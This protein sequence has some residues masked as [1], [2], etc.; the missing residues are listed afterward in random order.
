VTAPRR[1]TLSRQA[2]RVGAL[3]PLSVLVGVPLAIWPA[4]AVA[5]LAALAGLLCA[6]GI[7]AGARTFVLAGAAAALVEYALALAASAGPPRPLA[8]A[9]LGVALAL[10]LD[11]A[12]F[13]R[14]FRGAHLTT[15]ALLGQARHWLTSASLGA[16]AAVALA[17]LA[18]RV[19]VSGPPTLTAALAAL[20]AIGVTAGVAG[21]AR[22]RAAMNVQS[23]SGAPEACVYPGVASI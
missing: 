2:L 8:A 12:D 11:A 19:Q 23:S 18:G 17:T 3:V 1:D 10:L 5:A 21:A 13:L 15:R 4:G 20:A 9:V 7:A 22:R 14:R 6:V 16:L